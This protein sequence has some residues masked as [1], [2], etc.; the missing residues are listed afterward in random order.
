MPKVKAK[1]PKRTNPI[2][3]QRHK[4]RNQTKKQVLPV[5]SGVQ[6]KTSLQGGKQTDRD[7]K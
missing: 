1:Q 2:D 7:C 3:H 4:Q 6:Q 5:D